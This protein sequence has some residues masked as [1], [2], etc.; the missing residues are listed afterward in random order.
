[1]STYRTLVLAKRPTA[2]IIPG[3]TFHLVEGNTAPTES[4]LKDGEVLLET[5]YLSIDPGLRPWLDD[6][7]SYT[8]PVAIGE[9]MRGFGLGKVRASNDANFPVNSYARGLIGWTELKVIRGEELQ[10]VEVPQGAK[11]TDALG[12]LGTFLL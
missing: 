9:V 2:N 8:E 7:R 3:E 12:I 6:V 11:V 10:K 5:Y 4:D 1:M